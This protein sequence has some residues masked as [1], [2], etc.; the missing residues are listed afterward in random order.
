MKNH[1]LGRY[2]PEIALRGG[3]PAHMSLKDGLR[4]CAVSTD[5]DIFGNY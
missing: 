4:N 2:E 5:N 1:V 3:F